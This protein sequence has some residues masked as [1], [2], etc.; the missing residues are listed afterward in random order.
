MAKRDY[1]EVLGVGKQSSQD[2]IKK[3]YRKLALQYHPDRNP[4]N[5][6]AEEKFKEVSEAYEVLSD[7]QKRSRYDQFG[8]QGV[9][10]GS[11]GGGFGGGGFQGGF[12][13]IDL[14]EALRTFMGE[15][16]QGGGGGSIFDA[17]FGQGGGGGRAG[18]YAGADLRYDLTIP[19][20]E[21]AFGCKKELDIPR[22]ATCTACHGEGAA[23]GSKRTACKSCGGRGQIRS[24]GGFFSIARTC[25]TCRGA[26]ET[27]SNPC[28]QCGGEGRLRQRKKI[29]VRIPA[30]VENGSRLKV[31]GAGEDGVGGGP[32]GDLYVV[33]NVQPHEVFERQEDDLICQ[34]P[35]GLPLLALGGE[36]EVPTL[37]GKA[38]IKIPAGTQS[39]RIFRIKGRGIAN[40]HGYG[41]GDVIVKV[42]AETP[43]HLTEEQRQLF[44]RLAETAGEKTYPVR[45]SFLEKAKKFLS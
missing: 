13:G 41:R 12:G 19:F 1:Y 16:G 39:G 28:K 38:K 5:K 20:E 23:P 30:G 3:A 33:L 2:D 15:F 4:G 11:G 18:A 29:T 25:P 45:Q 26:G 22:M 42:T 14:E 44:K 43:A 21:A 32:A 36:L 34:M 37:E 9:G 31:G 10:A 35:V 27:I 7:A 6:E 24:G 40:V 8:H 17:F